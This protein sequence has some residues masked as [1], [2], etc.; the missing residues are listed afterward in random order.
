MKIEEAIK[1]RTFEDEVEKLAINLLFTAQWLGSNIGA[2]LKKNKLTSQQYNVLRIL[3]GQ[4]PKPASVML[5]KERM[6][7]RE[8]NAS[9]L[10][11]KLLA[12]G[13]VTRH[14]CPK[15]RRQVDVCLTESGID[16]LKKLN[17]QVKA[18]IRKQLNTTE[19][20]AR[21]LNDL[22]DKLRN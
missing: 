20:E 13:Y 21:K 2:L 7:D 15:D 18:E 11:D 12:A 6:M 4:H 5:I 19:A 3:K 10:V 22:L 1:Q 9:R 17:P 8:S 16:L 14:Q